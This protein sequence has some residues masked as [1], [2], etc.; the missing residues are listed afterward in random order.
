MKKSALVIGIIFFALVMIVAG[1]IWYWNENKKAII[2][3]EL[4]Y[5][6]RNKTQGLY[7][8]HYDSLELDEINGH[9]SVSSFTLMYDSIKYEQLKKENKEP[10]IILNI[11]IP[12]IRIVGVE[13]PRALIDKEISGRHVTLINPVIEILY[14]NAGK[15]STRNIPDKEIYEQILGNLN[16][17]KFD[18]VVISGAE[19]TTK[20]LKTGKTLVHFQNV[21]ISLLKV[22]VDSISSTD[23]TRI[24]FA[25]EINFDCEK[26]AWQ[27]RNKLYNYQVDS[28][29][30]H[31]ATSDI[32]I[33]NFS[34]LPQAKEDEFV[35]KFSFQTDRF[36]FS[37]RNIQL[38]NVNFYQL[39]KELINADS[40]FI[41][42]ASFKIYRDRTIPAD[43]K[44]RVG[45]YP[46]QVLQDIPVQ[47]DIKKGIARNVF[48]EY[49]EKSS[50]THQ[51]GKVRLWSSVSISNITN[52]K[53]SIANN[54][55]MV[56]DIQS[57]LLN[58][59]PLSVRWAFH[60]NN[61]ADGRFDIRG[62]LGPA[63]ATVFNVLAE[64]MGPARFKSGNIKSLEFD[65]TGNNYKMRGT[66]KLLYDDLHVSLLK[67]DDDSIHFKSKKVISLFANM[68]IKN[69]NPDDKDKPARVA[70]IDFQRDTHRSIFNFAWKSLFEG[71]K[72]VTG[73][74]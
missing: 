51:S 54:D 61:A 3:G 53:E 2:R 7:K 47:I 29:A 70:T 55:L 30:L 24:L 48:L 73:A 20:N 13:T 49:K 38:R 52:N 71:I 12:Q 50:I 10:S 27:S 16:L 36:D 65:L 63:D 64:P 11:S 57:R 17:I 74:K 8:V 40:L 46:Q 68:K 60:L 21:S 43:N 41:G 31:S 26:F 28:L 14:T 62:K 23:T 15:D 35:R 58:K 44:N 6:I 39:T 34:V 19:I 9:L 45:T 59:V 4:E 22:A 5:A 69:K 33:K 72:E 56:F 66:V 25:K 18:S 37:I 1:G 32:S 67:K 42:S